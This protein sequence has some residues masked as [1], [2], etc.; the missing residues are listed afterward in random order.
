MQYGQLEIYSKTKEL[1]GFPPRNQPCRPLLH[2]Q[3]CLDA[4]YRSAEAA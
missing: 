4:R 1:T 3:M 2:R